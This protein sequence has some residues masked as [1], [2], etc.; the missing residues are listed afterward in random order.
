MNSEATLFAGSLNDA[1]PWISVQLP[2][3][4][5]LVII[6]VIL[7][8]TMLASGLSNKI[9]CAVTRRT[10]LVNAIVSNTPGGVALKATS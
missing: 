5:S 8:V 6:Q 2:L 10:A 4:A 3:N 1:G 9:E 7:T